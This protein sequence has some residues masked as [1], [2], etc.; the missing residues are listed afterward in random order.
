[1]L[2]LRFRYG[3]GGLMGAILAWWGGSAA[4]LL[5]LAGV[6]GF[7]ATRHPLGVLI[8]S[9][10]R[11]SLTHLQL[12]TW[13]IVIL[14]LLSGALF[15][16]LQHSVPDP[17]GLT[18]PPELLAVMGISVGSAVLVSSAKAIRNVRNPTSVA[19][20]GPAPDQP[21]LI[22]I[23]LL[24]EG[25]YADQAVDLTKFQNFVI[26]IILVIAYVAEA[27]HA[28]IQAKTATAFVA[29][30]GF[31][32]GFLTLLAI[33][34]GGHFLGKLIPAPGKPI[35]LTVAGRDDVTFRASVNTPGPRPGLMWRKPLPPP[36]ESE[37]TPVADQTVQRQIYR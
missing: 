20:S 23:F 8:D 11:Y 36:N 34:N 24:E 19:A 13:T 32:A 17:L 31:S 12:T 7:A 15:G 25:A 6:V 29:L 2:T 22:Q 16:R 18:I 10:G 33:G 37:T 14:S 35:G 1:M 21:K 26:T 28:I 5:L 9:R 3:L 27:S 4:A 30:P